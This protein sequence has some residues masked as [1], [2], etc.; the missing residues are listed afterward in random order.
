MPASWGSFI[1]NGEAFMDEIASGNIIGRGGGGE[2]ELSKEPGM[3]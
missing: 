3:G 2:L 1:F